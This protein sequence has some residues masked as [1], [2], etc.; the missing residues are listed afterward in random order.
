MAVRSLSFASDSTT[1]VTG[2]DDMHINQYDLRAA[3]S[4]SSGTSANQI[5]SFSGHASWVLSAAVSPSNNLIAS[6]S[7]DR[8]VKIWD[9]GTRRCV[10]TFSDHSDQVCGDMLFELE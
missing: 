3:A 8:K 5:T 9:L 10:H 6:G 7:S 1:L 4:S 2:S